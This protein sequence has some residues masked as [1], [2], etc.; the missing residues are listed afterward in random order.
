MTSFV[1]RRHEIDEV[2]RLLYSARLVTL[3]GP[4]GVGKT[5]LALRAAADLEREFADGVWFV[6]LAPLEDA[7]LLADTVAA[8]GV[9]DQ[10][11]SQVTA[12]LLEFL[13]DKQLILVL[14][15]CEHL[16]DACAR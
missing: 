13:A 14:D 5:R 3:I 12:T 6:D 4:G 2:R 1:G 11:A 15:N 9:R 16:V 7:E 10:S 8:A